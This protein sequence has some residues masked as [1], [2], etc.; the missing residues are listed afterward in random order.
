MAMSYR[1]VSV[2][3]PEPPHNQNPGDR[4]PIF[5]PRIKMRKNRQYSSSDIYSPLAIITL[6][7]AQQL[8]LSR[9]DNNI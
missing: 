4:S 9:T 1:C 7:E 3:L 6:D 5:F 2:L 8:Q